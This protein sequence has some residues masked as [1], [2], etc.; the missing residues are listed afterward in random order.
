MF[1]VFSLLEAGW[2]LVCSH[3]L[4]GYR[5]GRGI[6]HLTLSRSRAWFVLGAIMALHAM[7]TYC[8]S[9][10]ISH[11]NNMVLVVTSRRFSSRAT[12]ALHS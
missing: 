5:F 4:P 8:A 9:C 3:T 12:G 6:S 2:V 1:L 11:V 10:S 7:G